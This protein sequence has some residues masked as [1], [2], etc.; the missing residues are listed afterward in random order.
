[1]NS[2]N[3][4]SKILRVTERGLGTS[5]LVSRNVPTPGCWP[6]LTPGGRF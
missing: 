4:S 3:L 6:V 5:V 2:L 1:L